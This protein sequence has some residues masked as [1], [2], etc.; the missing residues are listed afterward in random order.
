MSANYI[1]Y[2]DCDPG[3]D[4]ALALVYLL[5]SGVDIASIGVVSGNVGVAAAAE[6]TRRLLA[7]AGRTDI[8]IAIGLHD[9]IVGEFWGG[10]PVVHGA[11]GLGGVP[12]QP[13]D[14]AFD[15][16]PAPA[17]IVELAQRYGTQLRIIA[18]GPLTNIATAIGYEPA[19][20]QMVNAITIMGGAYQTPGNVTIHAEANIYADPHA[21]ARVLAAP[22]R[23]QL[24]VPLDIT[25][26]HGLSAIENKQLAE[27]TDP[28][29][30]RV[31]K[32]IDFYLNAYRVIDNRPDCL[33]HDP[34]AAALAIDAMTLSDAPECRINVTTD[35][36]PAFGKTVISMLAD[37]QMRESRTR[38]AL[39][40]EQDLVPLLLETIR[41]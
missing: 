39:S 41:R 31:S 38:I 27:S 35:H 4:D 19:L 21:A 22:W 13:T 34:L 23:N 20:P 9:P 8:P 29:L 2:V 18:L 5:R 6:N 1:Y 12:L 26:Q 14:V 36:I 16:L 24:L 32:M 25:T 15:R 40:T 17:R 10:A 11:D 37:A 28:L 33:L 7:L 30:Q 3:I